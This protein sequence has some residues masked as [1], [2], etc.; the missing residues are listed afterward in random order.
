MMSGLR[1]RNT[2][3]PLR[4]IPM[5][6]PSCCRYA[7][8]VAVGFTLYQR[9]G[10][11]TGVTA[12]IDD[13]YD[14]VLVDPELAPFFENTSMDALRLMQREL[15]CAALDGPVE[16]TGT[17]LSHAHQGRGIGR[18]HFS[19]FADH[20]LDTLQQRFDIAEE[21][22]ISPNTVVRHVSNILAKTG[23]A[24][25]TEAARYASQHGLAE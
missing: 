11:L 4:A 8:V 22:M 17:H 15:F 1:A 23:S 12:L 9:I 25:R 16:Y 14:R 2:E 5:S 19:R 21:L 24:N 20:L 7:A 18:H 6:A 3:R 13:F 10:G